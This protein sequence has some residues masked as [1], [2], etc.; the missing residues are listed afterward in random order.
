MAALGIIH[1]SKWL[2]VEQ[3]EIIDFFMTRSHLER[4]VL[5]IVNFLHVL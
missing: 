1:L 4:K 2:K 5:I 3:E